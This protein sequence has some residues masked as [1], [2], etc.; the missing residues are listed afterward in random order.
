[1][2][3][4]PI[5]DVVIGLVFIYLLYSLLATIIQE[6]ISTNLNLRAKVLKEGIA[7]MLDDHHS[8]DNLSRA[9]YHHPLIKY[10]GQNK[11]RSK[12]SYLSARNFSKV[13]I[14]LLRGENVSLA[15]NISPLIQKALSDEK[16]QWGDGVQIS[17][18]TL[19]FLKSL[20]IEAQSD[21]EKFTK[22]VEQWFDD[23]MERA[24]GWFK[25]KTQLI[26]FIIGFSFA[27]VF[28]IDS[29]SIA[30]KLGKDPKL[31]AQIADNAGVFIQ[32]NKELIN[33]LGAASETMAKDSLEAFAKRNKELLD[34]S[35][36][37]FNENITES[38]KLLGLGW[39]KTSKNGEEFNFESNFHWWSI[40]GW[41]ISALAIS[42]G[43]PFWFD[44]LNK[45]MQ[46]RSSKKD[47]PTSAE[48][49]SSN[50]QPITLNLNNPTSEEAVG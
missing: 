29:I 46:L 41:L 17:P 25:K 18:Q 39:T 40:F 9:F 8:N 36:K 13:L 27:I 15:Q 23:T 20:W 42:L 3:N 7:R 4:S 10:L 49:V 21:V 44:L 34:M 45:L 37:L 38:N 11:S 5:L 26:L 50:T 12:P 16:T 48:K 28:N 19:S 1:M 32:N 31:A 6:L 47:S 22:L 2:F 35:T 24:T 30:G 14:D 43:A 33:Q